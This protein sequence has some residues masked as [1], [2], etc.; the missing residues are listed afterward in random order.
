MKNPGP[1]LPLPPKPV[2]APEEIRQ[3]IRQQAY[4]LFE[5]R[6]KEDGHDF[7]DWI[8]A[9][10]EVVRSPRRVTLNNAACGRPCE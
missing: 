3:L 4:E 9:E 8:A 5:Q 2:R 6:G 7:D 10:S 1:R